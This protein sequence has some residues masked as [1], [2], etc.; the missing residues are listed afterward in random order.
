MSYCVSLGILDK[1]D[2]DYLKKKQKTGVILDKNS[3]H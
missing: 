2:M 3:A 1:E